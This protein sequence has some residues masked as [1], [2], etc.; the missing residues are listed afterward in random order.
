MGPAGEDRC[1]LEFEAPGM[2]FSGVR[3]EAQKPERWAGPLIRKMVPPGSCL[4]ERNAHC[5]SPFV[6]SDS[7]ISA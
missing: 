2:V 7:T 5:R 6:M 1:V 4:K 3:G